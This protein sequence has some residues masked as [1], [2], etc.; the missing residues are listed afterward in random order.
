MSDKFPHPPNPRLKMLIVEDGT[1][2][3][4]DLLYRQFRRKYQ[5]FR[6]ESGPAALEILAREGEVAVIICDEPTPQM[7]VT[8]F[9]RLTAVQ[10]PDTS[11]IMLISYTEHFFEAIEAGQLCHYIP[12]PWN[13]E[14]LNVFVSRLV[15]TY[16]LRKARTNEL[17]QR[18]ES[19]EQARQAEFQARRDAIPRLLGMGLSV[20]QVA[21]ALSLSVEEVTDNAGG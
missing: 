7:S 10:Y 8:E 1:A 14:E 18:G 19:A 2:C 6:A 11:Q 3:S 13:P 4:I 9:L 16:T 5:V 17:P 12:K 20:E 15:D 21:E